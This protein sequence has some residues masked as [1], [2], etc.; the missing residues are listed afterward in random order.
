MKVTDS[1]LWMDGGTMTINAD[2]QNGQSV[3]IEFVQ[4]MI[5]E[6]THEG[7]FAGQLYLDNIHVDPRSKLE[8]EIVEGLKKVL[9]GK[10]GMPW[11]DKIGLGEKIEYLK[12][13]KYLADLEMMKGQ[14]E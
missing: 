3:L 2:L 10:G 5:L 4:N 8:E 1:G 7:K 6:K 12:S 13:E 14:G 11:M 9:Y